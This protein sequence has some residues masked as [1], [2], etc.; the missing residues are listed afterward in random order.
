MPPLV[1]L[2]AWQG[3]QVL[4][5]TL[6]SCSVSSLFAQQPDRF[7]DFSIA[8]AGLFLDY[9][10]NRVTDEVMEQLVK[11]AQQRELPAAIEAMFSGERIN[12]SENRPVLHTVL[13]SRATQLVIDGVDVIADVQVQLG[14]MS[15][16]VEEICSGRWRGMTGKPITDV[17]NIGIGGSDLGPRLVVEALSDP[18]LPGLKVQF[19][20]NVDGEHLLQT[21]A[22][23]HPETTVF[24]VTSKSFS[25]RDTLLNAAS[26][27]Q[28]FI[29]GMGSDPSVDRHFIAVTNNHQ[30]ALDFGINADNILQ[31]WDWVGGRYS[32]WSAAGL[33]IALACGMEAFNQLRAGAA[34]LDEHFRHAPLAENLPVMLAL[35]G[36]WNRNFQDIDTLMVAPYDQRLAALP[37]YLQQADMESNGKSV[38]HDGQTVGVNTGPVVWGGVGSN[39]QHCYMQLLHQGSSAV[40]SDFIVSRQPR[41]S[42]RYA[43][44]HQLLVANCIAQ[45]QALMN[46]R[47]QQQAVGELK[48]SG[49][50]P[51]QVDAL[52]AQQQLPGNQ[53]SNMIM[54]DQLGPRELGA[55]LA[56]YEQK[57]FVQGVIWGINSFD[58]W[59]VALGKELAARLLARMTEDPTSPTDVSGDQGD[60]STVGLLRRFIGPVNR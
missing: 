1:D 43:G 53:P 23:L 46:G 25:T 17:V 21:L 10:K 32:L 57:I 2:Q 19:V 29:D 37:A 20:S 15:H 60:S 26:A 58:Q 48:N 7:E 41:D 54:V 18:G 31:I 9:S 14:K 6:D 40:A 44:Q 51:Q 50:N 12:C 4:A 24:I 39:G 35:I 33:S 8:A 22:G 16:L 47:S 5:Q 34:D 45:A 11:L 27:R 13:R 30:A 49:L 55:L 28:W 38:G 36:I 56:M 42:S 52:A 59:G 3:L